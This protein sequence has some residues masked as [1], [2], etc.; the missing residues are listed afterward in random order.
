MLTLLP[1]QP[2]KEIITSLYLTAFVLVDWPSDGARVVDRERERE[3]RGACGCALS[4]G[5]TRGRRKGPS[6]QVL[7][8]QHEP[9]WPPWSLWPSIHSVLQMHSERGERDSGEIHPRHSANFYFI[10]SER[11][12]RQLIHIAGRSLW[13]SLHK[14]H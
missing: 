5:M 9:P 11:Q 2:M 7:P 12:A 10:K 13:N 6:V 4:F 3:R 8:T 1:F 14:T